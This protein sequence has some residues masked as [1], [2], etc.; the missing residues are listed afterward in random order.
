M[1]V[2]TDLLDSDKYPAEDLLVTY[3]ARWCIE[4]VF[5]K[6]T[7][8]FHLKNLISTTPEGTVFQFAFCMLLY[9]MIQLLT[10][11]L[12]KAEKIPV[13]TISQENVFYDVHRQM[14]SWNE[15]VPP[16]TTANDL[17]PIPTEQPFRGT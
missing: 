6:I 17:I 12:A 10:Q 16:S 11:Y 3:H 14:I 9:N 5:H 7:D 2:I 8:V 13:P 15:L 1:I 4:S